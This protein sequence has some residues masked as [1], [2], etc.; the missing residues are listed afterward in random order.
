[1][2]HWKWMLPLKTTF[3]V[4]MPLLCCISLIDQGDSFICYRLQVSAMKRLIQWQAQ[5]YYIFLLDYVK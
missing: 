1:M 2:C 3:I 5:Q 4:V